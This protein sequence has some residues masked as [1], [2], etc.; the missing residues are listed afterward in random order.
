MKWTLLQI[1]FVLV[2]VA[3]SLVFSWLVIV[4]LIKLITIC[5]NLSFSLKIATGIWLVLILIRTFFSP[6]K[7]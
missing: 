6:S 7:K 4:G 5:F 3:A 2:I 1:L